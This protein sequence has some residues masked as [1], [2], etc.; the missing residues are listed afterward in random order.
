MSG[1]QIVD[2]SILIKK[3]LAV[4]ALLIL[5]LPLLY[6]QPDYLQRS[7]DLSFAEKNMESYHLLVEMLP[8]AATGQ[9]RADICWRLSRD[10]LLDTDNRHCEG[11]SAALLVSLYKEGESW[12]DHAIACDPNNPLG[13]YLKASNIARQGQAR[14]NPSLAQVDAMRTLLVK[15]VQLN[16]RVSGP[17]YVLGQLYEQVPGWP[18]SFGNAE[19]SVSLGRKALDAGAAEL[20]AGL[21]HFVPPD[22]SI[23]L[24]RHLARRNWSSEKRFREQEAAARKFNE[25]T[26]PVERNFYYEG[27]VQIP[28]ISDRAEARQLCQSV[29]MQLQRIPGRTPSQNT[30]FRNA[31]ETL[32][33]LG[34]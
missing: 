4:G 19:G 2:V 30:D 11:A 18:V 25:T 26:D 22:Y 10:I 12:A 34:E 27:T 13:Y 17:W 28:P 16:P 23:Q 6:A 1:M 3:L 33:A 5:T 14:G 29:L 9:E 21:I 15:A 8:A 32:A 31:Q 7:D 24:A 20:S